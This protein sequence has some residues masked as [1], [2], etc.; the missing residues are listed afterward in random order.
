VTDKQKAED[1]ARA[2]NDALALKISEYPD[3]FGGFASLAVHACDKAAK[4]LERC[5]KTL[6]FKGVMWNGYCQVDRD[7]NLVYLDEHRCSPLWAAMQDLDVP[8]YLHPRTCI[9]S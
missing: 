7:D 8:L 3:R 9:S 4:E 6:G 5:I 1:M 2:V